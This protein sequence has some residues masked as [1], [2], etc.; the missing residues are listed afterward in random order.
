MAPFVHVPMAYFENYP[1]FFDQKIWHDFKN[2]SF[3]YAEK[4]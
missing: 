2:E 4:E 3:A 1:K